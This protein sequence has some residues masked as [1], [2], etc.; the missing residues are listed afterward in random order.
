VDSYS[1]SSRFKIS[2]D[3]FCS[4]PISKPYTKD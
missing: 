1:D 3:N 4:N 2:S